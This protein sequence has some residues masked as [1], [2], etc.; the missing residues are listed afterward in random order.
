MMMVIA[1]VKSLPTAQCYTLVL[2]LAFPIPSTFFCCFAETFV[3]YFLLQVF[4][5]S[6]ALQFSMLL[7]PLLF[8]V[9]FHLQCPHSHHNIHYKHKTQICC[10]GTSNARKFKGHLT[11][12]RFFYLGYLVVFTLNTDFFSSSPF[13]S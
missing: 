5:F 6:H 8:F 10:E 2:Q 7:F 4:A 3:A 9:I 12:L 1:K 11:F 13:N